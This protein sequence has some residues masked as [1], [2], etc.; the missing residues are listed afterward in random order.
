M[1]NPYA[2]G[3]KIYLRAPTVEDAKGNWHEWFSDP[4]ITKYLVDRFL[5]NSKEKQI[6][7]YE[8]LQDSSDRVVFSICNI[9]DDAHIWICGLS[10]IN[11]FHGNA[12]IAYIIGK[13]QPNSTAIIEALRLLL[14]ASFNRLNL[15]N[16]RSTYAASNPATPLIDKM[17]GFKVVGKLK[18]YIICQGQRD[19]LIMSQLSKED[20]LL[21]NKK[22]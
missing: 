7:F 15:S 11:W 8:S 3:S 14:E 19:D 4:E 10:A 5:P 13:E 1:N 20:W 16:L 2:I 17:F 9:E 22:A 18:N 12:D 21:R 6:A